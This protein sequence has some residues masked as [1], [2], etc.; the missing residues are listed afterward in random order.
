MLDQARARDQAARRPPRLRSK[1]HLVF[2]KRSLSAYLP[3]FFSY[4]CLSRGVLS[5]YNR[6]E[7]FVCFRKSTPRWIG[8]YILYTYVLC[9]FILFALWQLSKREK[10]LQNK[11]INF[12]FNKYKKVAKKT[13]VKGSSKKISL[14]I[15]R[16]NSDSEGTHNEFGAFNVFKIKWYTDVTYGHRLTSAYHRVVTIVKE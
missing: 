11:K 13:L 5:L 15:F 7:F 1:V 4:V 12:D 8:V 6:R 3:T 14:A 9:R 16:L 2:S 10:K